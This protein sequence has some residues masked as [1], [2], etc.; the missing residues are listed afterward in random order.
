M[1]LRYP[2]KKMSSREGDLGEDRNKVNLGP[3]QEL[4]RPWVPS[5]PEVSWPS[6]QGMTKR[7]AGP[8]ES[9]WKRARAAPP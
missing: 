6:F 3:S 2:E 7:E 8:K 1:R 9:K 4:L 5:G